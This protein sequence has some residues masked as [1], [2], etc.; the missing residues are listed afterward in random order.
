[1][2]LTIYS[3]N[4]YLFNLLIQH[5]QYS[6]S[7]TDNQEE[8]LKL[9][10]DN[11]K[12]VRI[13]DHNFADIK[14]DNFLLPT[15]NLLPRGEQY[16]PKVTKNTNLHF[17]IKPFKFQSLL[18]LLAKIHNISF[19]QKNV[20]NLSPYHLFY[21]ENKLILDIRNENQDIILT[22]KEAILIKFLCNNQGKSITKH[23]LLEKAWG[24]STHLETHTL[25][26]HI[27]RLRQKLG[28]YIEIITDE[29]GYKI[30]I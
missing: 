10:A 24:H 11:I 12:E 4:N 25:E 21:Y 20:I 30:I 14:A 18:K 22:E 26:T 17:I 6:V 3:S 19:I 27:Y 13:I 15:I 1:L 2:H 16:I 9:P 28:N 23:E 29:N 8:L 7:V 5:G